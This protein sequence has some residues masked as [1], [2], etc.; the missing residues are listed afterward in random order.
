MKK[1]LLCFLFIGYGFFC[2]AEENERLQA[3]VKA[4]NQKDYTATRDLIEEIKKDQ[5]ITTDERLFCLIYESKN[6]IDFAKNYANL[7]KSLSTCEQVL[8]NLQKEESAVRSSRLSGLSDSYY[9]LLL[10]C[11]I[12]TKNTAKAFEA[13]YKIENPDENAVYLAAFG[14][15][16]S[17][18]DYVKTEQLLK[19][20]LTKT[21]RVDFKNPEV[22]LLYAKALCRNEKYKESEN[23]YSMLYADSQLNH[24]EIFEY[25]KLLFVLEKYQSAEVKAK[26]SKQ[27]LADYLCGLCGIN[28]KQWKNAEQY[29]DSYL[30]KNAS[31][32]GYADSAAYYKAYSVYRQGR[33]KEAYKLFSNFADS[34]TE[35]TFARHAYELSAKCAVLDSDFKNAAV[36]AEK[37]VKVSFKEEEKQKAVVFCAEIYLDCGEYDKAY[38]LLSQYTNEKSDFALKCRKLTADIYVKTKDYDRAD[39]VYEKII[40]DYPG[41]PEA[42]ESYYKRGELYYTN[43]DYAKAAEKFY[44]Y[45]S[46]Y[47]SGKYIEGAYYFAGESY[48]KSKQYE[49]S[50]TQNKN[51][52]NK[53]P[54]SIYT[55]GAYKNLFEAS[56]QL[57]NISEAQRAADYMMN[58]YKSQAVSDGIPQKIKILTGMKNGQSKA[59]SEK[60]VEYETKGGAS[61][62]EGRMA[63]YELFTMY[64]NDGNETEAKKIAGTLYNSNSKR[65]EGE[66]YYLGEIAV[67]FARSESGTKQAEL[68]LKAVEYYRMSSKDT[69]D[70]EAVALYSATDAFLKDKKTADARQTADVLKKL[71]PS[72]RQ[73]K[74]VDKL[75]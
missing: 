69:Q 26:E 32:Y 50:V 73:A 48:L 54:K 16:D 13:Y 49:R 10:Y 67:F 24:E 41:T 40:K 72:S 71:Y 12:Q 59:L 27:P 1:L 74:N 18:K 63:G 64:V 68:Y 14:Y 21:G 11:Y 25:A 51:L 17:E 66:Y 65:G 42:E 62:V 61:T 44:A 52:I 39:N 37:L 30:K 19:E 56:Y 6:E 15:F 35:L 45:I 55:Y 3:V 7:D 46:K 60:Q 70:K 34:T 47:S 36:Q 22:R 53:F 28:T 58:N 5:D 75:F 29:L 33:Y 43:Q 8:K 4:Y 9:S 38:N 23:Y 31:V 2:F 20:Y 57:E